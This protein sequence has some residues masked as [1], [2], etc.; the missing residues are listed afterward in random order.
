MLQCVNVPEGH[1]WPEI[2]VQW[3]KAEKME[4]RASAAHGVPQPQSVP[5]GP[6]SRAAQF[7]NQDHRV[8]Q[9]WPTPKSRVGKLEAAV[10]TLGEDDSAIPGLKEAL[11]RV[12]GQAQAP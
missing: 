12:R 11:E 9:A 1:S 7:N 5:K 10:V 2:T 6:S 4:R 8:S 3:P